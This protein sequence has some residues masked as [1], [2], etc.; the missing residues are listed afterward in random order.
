MIRVLGGVLQMISFCMKCHGEKEV[1]V[2]SAV[3][4]RGMVTVTGDCPTCGNEL[5]EEL[6]SDQFYTGEIHNP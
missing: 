5:K 1:E 2:K 6:R 4:Q 3:E